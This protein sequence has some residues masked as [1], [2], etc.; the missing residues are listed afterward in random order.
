[1]LKTLLKR[2]SLLCGG[3]AVVF[4]F[5]NCGSSFSSLQTSNLSSTAANSDS[6]QSDNANDDF[7]DPGSNP[8]LPVT[9]PPVTVTPIPGAQL[10]SGYFVPQKF[11][12]TAV[13]PRPDSETGSFANSN[14]NAFHRWACKC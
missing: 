7:S 11:P 6:N 14:V 5:Q 8:N 13:F 4:G 2:F 9:N 12:M 1:M 3:L 10:P